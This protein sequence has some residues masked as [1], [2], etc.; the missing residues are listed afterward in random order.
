MNQSEV[1]TIA[2]LEP[3]EGSQNADITLKEESD[4]PPAQ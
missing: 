1:E 3:E 4:A 2:E